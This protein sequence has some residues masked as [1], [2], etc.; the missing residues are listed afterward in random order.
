M[1]E[2]IGLSTNE[3]LRV[4][5]IVYI[6]AMDYSKL[7]GY[8]VS[9]DHVKFYG[10]ADKVPFSMYTWAKKLED[11]RTEAWSTRL[12]QAIVGS[13]EE[14]AETAKK[15]WAEWCKTTTYKPDPLLFDLHLNMME[16]TDGRTYA[17][18]A[19]GVRLHKAYGRS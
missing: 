12:P 8:V 19:G 11:D 14:A 7:T 4:G 2:P 1:V 15:I 18:A 16:I 10:D 17:V 9:I 3:F 5:P 13:Y 6:C